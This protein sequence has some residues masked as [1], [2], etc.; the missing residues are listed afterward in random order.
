MAS[1]IRV[2]S[3]G[4]AVLMAVAFCIPCG[5]FTGAE[6]A[7][8]GPLEYPRTVDYVWYDMFNVPFGEWWN[9]RAM[10]YDNDVPLTDEYP[11]LYRHSLPPAGN[12]WIYS[13]MRLSVDGRN[14]SEINMTER[15][16]FLPMSGNGVGGTAE[17]DWYLQYLTSEEMERFPEAT[18]AWNDGWVVSLN[19]T[20]SLDEDAAL[21]V[22]KDLTAEGFIDFSDWWVS[23]KSV[24]KQDFINFFKR[25]AGKER[26]DIYPAYDYYFTT[27]YWDIE[28]E[29]VG[30]EIVLHYDLVTWGMEVLLSMWMREAFMPTEWY[31]EDMNFH[32]TIGPERTDIDVDTTVAYA[33]FAWESVYAQGEPCWVWHAMMQDCVWA[34]PPDHRLSLINKYIDPDGD[35]DMV[36]ALTYYNTAPGNSWY[37]HDMPYHYVP[38]AWNL[39]EGETLRLRWPSGD[40]TFK[41]HL[42]AG[43]IDDYLS[44]MAMEMSEPFWS[45][46]GALSPGTFTIYNVT[47]EMCF[48]GPI[49]MWHW[50]QLQDNPDH[51]WLSDEWDRLGLLPHGAPYIEFAPSPDG[52]HEGRLA[53]NTTPSWE[54]MDDPMVVRYDT[55]DIEVTALN[56]FGGVDT[57]Y[58]GTVTFSANRTG[59]TF[60]VDYTFAPEDNGVAVLPGLSF[61]NLGLHGLMVSDT[62]PESV[63]VPGE[64]DDILVVPDAAVIDHFI[65]EVP[66]TDGHVLPGMPTDV[67]VW[68]WNQYDRLFDKYEG[69]I[70][71]S[72]DAP[73]GTFTLPADYT[74]NG[75]ASAGFAVIPGLVFDETGTYSL[76]VLDTITT[77]ASGIAE[78]IVSAHPEIDYRLYDMFEQPWGEWWYWRLNSFYDTEMIL[79]N[80]PHKY[81][82][83]YNPDKKDIH[84][85]ITA[86][87]RWNVSATQMPTVSIRDPAIMPVFGPEVEGASAQVGVYFE[88][89]HTDWWNNYWIPVWSMD[90]EWSPSIAA[91]WDIQQYDGY[92]LGTIYTV[93]MNREA[94]EAWMN[95]PMSADPMAWWNTNYETYREDW[96]DWIEYQGNYE[97]DIYPGYE[98][99]YTDLGTMTKLHVV[100]DDIVL[101]IA[102]I[103]YGYEV[104]I[105]RWMTDRAICTHEPFMEDF[106]LSAHFGALCGDVT[107]D[108][109]A[110]WSLQAVKAN[111]TESAAAWVWRPEKVDY[112]ECPGSDYNKYAYLQYTSWFSGDEEFG[113]YVPYVY[114]PTY[115]NLTLDM[116]LSIQLPDRGDVIAYRGLQLPD[117]S[118]S[119][120]RDYGDTTPYERISHYGP[121]WLGWHGFPEVPGAPDLSSMY[122]N[123]SKTLIVQGPMTFENY[124]HGTGQLY[125]GAPW[126]EFN[127]A[128]YTWPG[129]V[130]DLFP[131]ADAG[132]DIL[133]LAGEEVTF[134]SSNSYDDIEIVNWTWR[135]WYDGSWE[136][137]YGPSPQYEFLI[138]GV[139][140]VTLTVEDGLGQT[141]TD[142]VTVTV[143]GVIPEFA[144]V[145]FAVITSM[146]AIVLTL[147]VVKRSRRRRLG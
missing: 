118:I 33:V 122:D 17:I 67:H 104:L 119:D 81:T 139:Y 11:Y 56:E 99:P 40:Q 10:T 132:E 96:I 65:V 110:Q 1:V 107:Y 141:D 53:L 12:S 91:N 22:I 9:M 93:T 133:A 41:V 143:S 23:N 120:L 137:I 82:M 16:E 90:D 24:V 88:Y 131:V 94:A 47:N 106:Q 20:V 15:P 124:H 37:G 18:A 95:L 112:V 89:L 57:S 4:L 3:L 34:A 21:T 68:A 140:E 2:C 86:P 75:F 62:D 128:N 64:L 25:E 7:G 51:S 36:D 78:V 147:A 66:G 28:A 85:I 79:S 97:F 35:G 30:D 31:F 113:N 71:F 55:V 100:G 98:W 80:E 126:I 108:G 49:D 105:T 45:D 144:S 74:F 117:G 77:S 63:H 13:S 6:S 48:S 134:D 14:M 59:V 114:T 38:G 61:S 129:S 83:V 115:F 87:Y 69:T 76:T 111:G 32:A 70:T 125:H 138:E 26:L 54:D 135:F 58:R 102:H 136:E 130:E 84:G 39:T 19:G 121:M 73:L 43:L 72:T 42:G 46:A 8:P 101:T 27:L 145:T 5:L 44:P 116:T 142:T 123:Y 103:N 60:P 127:V 29:K 92:I 50:S 52:T 109:V 146:V